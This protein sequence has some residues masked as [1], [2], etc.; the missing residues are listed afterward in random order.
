MV[1]LL[2]RMQLIM[3]IMRGCSPTIVRSHASTSGGGRRRNAARGARL[4]R[5]AMLKV[6]IVHVTHA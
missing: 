3:L 5:Q 4:G 6:Q 2:M 1:G